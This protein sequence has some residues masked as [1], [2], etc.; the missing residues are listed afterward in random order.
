MP[1]TSLC[2]PGTYILNRHY[3]LKVVREGFSEEVAYT[4]RHGKD[5]QPCKDLRTQQD[6]KLNA[7]VENNLCV[8]NGRGE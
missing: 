8:R 3:I 6:G 5:S 7:K 2:P 4:M 1:D